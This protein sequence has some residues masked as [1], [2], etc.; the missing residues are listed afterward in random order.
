M[1]GIQQNQLHYGTVL[2]ALLI[3]LSLL[4]SCIPADNGQKGGEAIGNIQTISAEE[5][6]TMLQDKS[7]V[8]LDVRTLDEYESGHIEGAHLLPDNEINKD[9]AAKYI[10]DESTTVIVYCRSGRR[11]ADA[12][13]TLMKL[14]YQEVYDLGGI[15]SWPYDIVKGGK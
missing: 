12:A 1:F 5:A 13:A 6:R 15:N 4:A 8:L 10:P 9:T 2:V 3:S 14:G 11:S 7:V